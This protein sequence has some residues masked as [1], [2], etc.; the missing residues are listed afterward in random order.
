MALQ[1]IFTLYTSLALLTYL[2]CTVISWLPGMVPLPATGGSENVLLP[3]AMA[4]TI[5]LSVMASVAFCWT[6]TVPDAL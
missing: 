3:A 5:R 1:A 4:V 6:F 2:P